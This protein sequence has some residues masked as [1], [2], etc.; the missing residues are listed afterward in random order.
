[1]NSIYSNP[2]LSFQSDCNINEISPQ[3]ISSQLISSENNNIKESNIFLDQ[4]TQEQTFTQLCYFPI[5]NTFKFPSTINIHYTIFDCFEKK[6]EFIQKFNESSIESL[7]NTGII[8][9]NLSHLE[10]NFN[11]NS[12]KKIKLSS[13]LEVTSYNKSL[14]SFQVLK[15]IEEI[16]FVSGSIYE[17]LI[18]YSKIYDLTIFFSPLI[19][20]IGKIIIF[21][22][23]EIQNNCKE[24][25]KITTN[26]N[27]NILKQGI[28]IKKYGRHNLLKPNLRRIFFSDNFEEFS[29]CKT[30]FT[31]NSKKIYKTDE[32]KE[33]KQKRQTKNFKRFKNCNEHLSFS[34]LISDRRIDC[35]A[36]NQE[37]KDSFCDALLKLIKK[38]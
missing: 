4:S 37:E 5:N 23:Q 26:L 8:S 9:Y 29:W 25:K 3:I 36:N 10:I 28:N 14:I 30:D 19:K 12:S 24:S 7:F 22:T 38:K 2:L 11:N 15:E 18:V 34:I 17:H 32:I 31:K 13:I 33:L 21:E 6:N 20:E 35:E 1:M 16:S 27:L